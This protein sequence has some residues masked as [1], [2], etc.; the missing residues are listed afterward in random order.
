M[1]A[2]L[3]LKKLHRDTKRPRRAE[4]RRVGAGVHHERCM[5]TESDKKKTNTGTQAV[6]PRM[7]FYSCDAILDPRLDFN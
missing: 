7:Y 6:R 4:W 2:T 1:A 3:T 5:N